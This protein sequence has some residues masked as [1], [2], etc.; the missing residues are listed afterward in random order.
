MLVDEAEAE[1]KKF[2]ES[3]RN[4]LEQIF[5]ITRE[6][7]KNTCLTCVHRQRWEAGNSV[8]QYCGILK[9]N[10]TENGKLKIKCK[11]KACDYY[12]ENE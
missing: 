9:S 11:T 3:I 2:E 6:V 7:T 1:F 12:R 5:E 10:R 8:I 4:D